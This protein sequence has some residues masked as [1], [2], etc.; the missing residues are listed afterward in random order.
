[1]F[2][3]SKFQVFINITLITLFTSQ[4]LPIFTEFLLIWKF[5]F[6]Q[7]Q[8]QRGIL[9]C[10]FLHLYICKNSEFYLGQFHAIYLLITTKEL[11]K[12]GTSWSYVCVELL[13]ATWLTSHITDQFSYIVWLGTIMVLES[14]K[15]SRVG[16]W[17]QTEKAPS[18]RGM[19]NLANFFLSKTTPSPDLVLFFQVIYFP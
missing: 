8:R 16:V 18:Q 2:N 3:I 13:R 6:M 14:C 15:E 7:W 1:M 12:S 4:Y 5:C 11:F 10:C 17:V 19:K 9:D